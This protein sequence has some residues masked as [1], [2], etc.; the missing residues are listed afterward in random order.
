M[1]QRCFDISLKIKVYIIS[2]QIGLNRVQTTPKN[3]PPYLFIISFLTSCLISSKL[4]KK[5]SNISRGE[6]EC[7]FILRNLFY[8]KLIQLEKIYFSNLYINSFYF[9]IKDKIQHISLDLPPFHRTLKL[10]RFELMKCS[11]SLGQ[12][13]LEFSGV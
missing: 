7:I 9:H 13:E 11:P 3:D 10:L 6:T 2:I 5:L 4:L 8:A 12:P 1:V